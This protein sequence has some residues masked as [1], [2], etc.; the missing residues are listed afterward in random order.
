[1]KT[2]SHLPPPRHKVV[3][4]WIVDGATPFP[5]DPLERL[6]YYARL[7]P[8]SHNS[9]PWKFR[10]AAGEIDVFAD[11]A[12][13]LRVADP[14]RR[15]LH[16]SVGCALEALRIA[17]D[18]AGYG[19]AVNYFPVEGDDTLVARVKVAFGGPKRE[20]PAAGLL[21]AI[22]TRRT[23]HRHFDPAKPVGDEDKKQ[24]YRSFEVGDVSLH[25]LDE[26]TALD[27]LAGLESRADALLFANPAYREELADAVGAGLL[28][29]SW[30][31]SKLGQFAVGHLPVGARM[32]H[33]D[34][35]RLASAPLVAL[36]TTRNDRPVDAVQA[37]EAF[38]RIALVA[39]SR[40]VRVQPVSQVL[41]VEETRAGIARLFDLGDRVAQHLFRLG[42]A[43]AEAQP[44][45]RRPLA[46]F[47]LREP[48]AR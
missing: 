45:P 25:F 43:E 26:R 28:K 5:N 33:G 23:S 42:H 24:L 48:A 1:M 47:L 37:G 27:L 16:L 31:I 7:A 35:E 11:H 20:N 6:V 30:L 46:S 32:A 4:G 9:Q 38:M 12:H 2:D 39:E 3:D 18:F 29:T 13:W 34:A 8:S 15:E 22:T 41:E 10:L 44:A 17:G 14:Q 36:L 21:E 40:D 19:T